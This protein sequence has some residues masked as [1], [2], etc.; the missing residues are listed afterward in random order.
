MQ[1]KMKRNEVSDTR[2]MAVMK[3]TS[4]QASALVPFSEREQLLSEACMII[5]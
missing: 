1:A 5:S 2:I 3:E 4:R